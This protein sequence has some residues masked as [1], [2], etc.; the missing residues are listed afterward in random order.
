MKRLQFTAFGDDLTEIDD[1]IYH[2][3]RKIEY[4]LNIPNELSGSHVDH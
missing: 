2:E 1:R 3:E 4:F